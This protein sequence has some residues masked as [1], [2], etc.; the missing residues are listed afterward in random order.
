MNWFNFK[1]DEK[2]LF[3]KDNE[4]YYTPTLGYSTSILNNNNMNYVKPEFFQE[5]TR[6]FSHQMMWNKDYIDDSFKDLSQFDEQQQEKLSKKADFYEGLYNEYIPGYTFI[7]KALFLLQ[8]MKEVAGQNNPEEF[9]ETSNPSQQDDF[10]K[11]MRDNLPGKGEWENPNI[12]KLKENRKDLNDF[13]KNLNFLRR[14][15]KVET[16][17]KSFEVKKKITDKRVHNAPKTKQKRLTHFEDIMRS[18]LYQK[19]LPDYEIRLAQKTLITNVPVKPET[20]KQ[21]IIILID[22]S[23]SMNENFKKEWVYAVVANRLQYAM[24]KECEVFI[25]LF[26]TEG[27]MKHYKFTHIYDEQSAL[28]F[29]KTFNF[30]PGGGDTKVGYV[31]NAIEKEILDNKK[32]Y[33]LNVD[34]SHE[35]PE[36]LIVNDGNDTVKTSVNWKTNAITI[37]QENDQLRALCE[38]TGGS[39]ISFNYD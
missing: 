19:M 27:T 38:D 17:G 33:N 18:P 26:L 22:D 8:Y 6:F 24:V 34:L 5:L 20:K 14:I 29:W 36:I 23:G 1:K 21:K 32:L 35:R 15:A 13:K 31:I 3:I 7:E 37:S 30:N 12:Q 9:M 2:P 25:S 4:W 10:M 16:F 28:E 39:Y 11:E